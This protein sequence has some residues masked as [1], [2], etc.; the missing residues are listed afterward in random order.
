[1]HLL[2]K[3]SDKMEFD[4]NQSFCFFLSLTKAGPSPYQQNHCWRKGRQSQAI[5]PKKDRFFEGGQN[6]EC[7]Q[8]TGGGPAA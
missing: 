8:A 5:F 6:P 4:P 2:T 1:M 7:K 3:P